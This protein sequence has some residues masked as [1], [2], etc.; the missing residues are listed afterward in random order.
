MSLN[1][2]N[3]LDELLVVLQVQTAQDGR[4]ILKQFLADAGDARRAGG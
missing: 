2:S 4:I 1:P 3:E